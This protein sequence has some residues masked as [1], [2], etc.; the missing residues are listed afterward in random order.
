[1]GLK[2]CIYCVT[3]PIVLWALDSI[4]INGIFKKNRYYAARA[5]YLIL[6]IVLSYLVVNFFFDFFTSSMI[7]K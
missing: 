5:L 2:A 1:M 7:I 4:N 6:S 3:V